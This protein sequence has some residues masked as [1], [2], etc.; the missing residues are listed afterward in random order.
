MSRNEKS[1]K[2]ANPP[3]G[4]PLELVRTVAKH[5]WS[6]RLGLVFAAVLVILAFGNFVLFI[7]YEDSAAWLDWIIIAFWMATWIIGSVGIFF[8]RD[9]FKASRAFGDW[10]TRYRQY[11][12]LTSFEF[13]S[14]TDTR[15]QQDIVNRLL[16]AYPDLEEEVKHKR[17][18]VTVS[19]EVSGK[20]G[21][22]LFDIVVETKNGRLWLG[23]L[24]A[25]DAAEMSRGELSSI[26]EEIRD[27]ASRRKHY[28][29][30]VLLVS[31]S[32]FSDEA[33]GS[34]KD[35]SKWR[36]LRKTRVFE[37]L[38]RKTDTGFCLVSAS[39]D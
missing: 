9:L 5:M 26:E 4:S 10:Q 34:A 8:L 38:I 25:D 17:A 12:L 27:I 21:P 13:L 15:L 28:R 19:G 39:D 36:D 14:P 1:S 22:H 11:A 23:R 35:S 33:V 3:A 24:R 31:R 7:V 30:E 18:K 29:I 37:V 32:D 20:K 2:D 6:I 16:T